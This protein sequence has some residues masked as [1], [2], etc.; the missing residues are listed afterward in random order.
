[1]IHQLPSLPYDYN[2]LEPYIDAQTMEI[3]HSRHHGGY[4]KKLNSILQGYPDLADMS[5]ERILTDIRKVPEEIRQAIRN[6]AGGH[7]NH[8]LFWRVMCP[9]GAGGQ[10]SG[11]LLESIESTFGGLAH[12]REEVTSH[13]INRFGSGWAWLCLDHNGRLEVMSTPNQDSPLMLG[14]VPILGVDVWE[15]AYYLKYQ[16]RRADYLSAWWNVVNWRRVADTYE[17]RLHKLTGSRQA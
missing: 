10:P 9:P 2:A 6:S 12:L 1:M 15:H 3:H 16:N 8:T 7:H 13:A 14:C 4:V 11:L 5:L 17:R